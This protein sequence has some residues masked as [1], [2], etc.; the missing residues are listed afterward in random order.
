MPGLVKVSY[1]NGSGVAIPP[2]GI[3]Q[4]S[5]AAGTTGTNDFVLSVTQPDGTTNQAF[6]IDD[7]KGS[8]ASGP[9]SYGTGCR[10]GEGAGWVLFNGDTTTLTP[11]QEVGPTGGSFAVS[12]SGTGYFYVGIADAS[13]NRIQV[14][15]KPASSGTPRIHF[16]I[17][18]FD[19][20]TNTANATILDVT[21]KTVP[22][23]L[24]YNGTVT[25]Y[26]VAGCY[27]NEVNPVD[28]YV[29]RHGF[30]DYMSQYQSSY[31]NCRWVVSALCCPP[32]S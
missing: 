19:T 30:A 22:P 32:T 17:N 24:N 11:W 14:I 9:Q 26:D 29:G 8:A 31:D 3:V 16:V 1:V 6:L 7:G 21:C 20:R 23:G 27:F 28:Y 4:C 25:I 10:L 15:S 12:S 13:N 18:S 5:G 2:W